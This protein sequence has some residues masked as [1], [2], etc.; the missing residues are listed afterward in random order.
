[1]RCTHYLVCLVVAAS[2]G[3]LRIGSGAHAAAGE[4]PRPQVITPAFGRMRK[5]EK[6]DG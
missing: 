3:S 1:M 6:R 5:D 4:G 2:A